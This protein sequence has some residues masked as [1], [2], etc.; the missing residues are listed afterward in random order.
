[1]AWLFWFSDIGNAEIR[2]KVNDTN[3]RI[4]QLGSL[5]HGYAIG[6]SKEDEIT[7]PKIGS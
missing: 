4:E 2:R 7:T 1:M 3:S 5:L 6:G